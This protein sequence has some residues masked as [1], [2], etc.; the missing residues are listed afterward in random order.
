MHRQVTFRGISPTATVME[1][2]ERQALKL[3]S[4][5]PSLETCDVVVQAGK[6]QRN[7]RVTVRLWDAGRRGALYSSVDE[8]HLQNLR[9]AVHRA[10]SALLRQLT[11][12]NTVRPRAEHRGA[13]RP[14]A[15]MRPR[16]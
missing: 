6:H 2:V 14:R 9:P 3:G 10:F 13:A 15:E 8:T 12:S 5:V 16:V 11:P 7:Y 1:E 4:R